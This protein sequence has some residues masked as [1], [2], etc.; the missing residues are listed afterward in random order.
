VQ[1]PNLTYRK[2]FRRSGTSGAWRDV[3]NATVNLTQAQAEAVTLSSAIII[4]RKGT[5]AVNLDLNVPSAYSN[6]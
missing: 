5:S 4:E 2:F 1:Q 3:A 6:L